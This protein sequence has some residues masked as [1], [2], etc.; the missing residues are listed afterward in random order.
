MLKLNS[1]VAGLIVEILFTFILLCKGL[2]ISKHE[3]Y[4][5]ANGFLLIN[6]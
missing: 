2:K 3:V 5:L 4:C 1:V 6:S